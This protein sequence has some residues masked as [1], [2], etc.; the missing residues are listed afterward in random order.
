MVVTRSVTLSGGRGD[1]NYV[2]CT[3]SVYMHLGLVANMLCARGKENACVTKYQ[4]VPRLGKV[5][6]LSGRPR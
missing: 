2:S 5:S 4:C 1:W 3:V 6:S